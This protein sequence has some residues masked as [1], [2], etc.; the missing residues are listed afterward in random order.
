[1]TNPT[2]L[3][4]SK[5]SLAHT[6]HGHTFGRKYSPTYQSWQSML[7]RTRYLARDTAKKH[8]GRGITVDPRWKT[9]E[10]FLS[11]MGER[12]IGTTLD[13][14]DN[15]GN[16]CAENCRWATPREQARNCRSTKLNFERAT[17]VALALLRGEKARMVAERFAI[18]ESLV[19]HVGRGDSWADALANARRILNAN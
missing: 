13:R 5:R 9:F 2:E 16:Y 1:M 10:N 14:I 4:P 19:R 15:D 17:E 6:R 7:A 18:S 8:V 11:D 3:L 12:P